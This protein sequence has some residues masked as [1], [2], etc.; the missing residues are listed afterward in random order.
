MCCGETTSTLTLDRLTSTG[1]VYPLLKNSSW[2]DESSESKSPLTPTNRHSAL[3][4]F[5]TF[6]TT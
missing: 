5:G 6:Y 4:K 3:P 1:G 2:A